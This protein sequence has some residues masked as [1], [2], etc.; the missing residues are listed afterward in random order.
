MGVTTTPPLET[1]KQ[2]N[3]PKEG[4]RGRAKNF[5]L[6]K[7]TDILA[8]FSKVKKKVPK[9]VDFGRVV[10]YNGAMMNERS[11]RNGSHHKEEKAD[12]ETE[13]QWEH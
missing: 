13:Y 9:G 5:F 11:G 12:G 1:H 3:V 7:N 2:V 4:R 10:G 8:D 6:L